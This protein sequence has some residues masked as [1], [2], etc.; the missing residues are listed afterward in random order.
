MPKFCGHNVWREESL[1]WM[2]A[3][4]GEFSSARDAASQAAIDKYFGRA[5]R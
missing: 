5:T 2:G 4:S 1:S 3:N